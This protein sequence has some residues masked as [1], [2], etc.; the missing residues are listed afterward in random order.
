[1]ALIGWWIGSSD[2]N[3]IAAANKKLDALLARTD[4]KIHQLEEEYDLGFILVAFSG[5]IDT[6]RIVPHTDRIEGDWRRCRVYEAGNGLLGVE[7]PPRLKFKGREGPPIEINAGS[8]RAIIPAKPG[9][10]T[11][12]LGA[13]GVQFQVECLQQEPIGVCAVIGFKEYT[14]Q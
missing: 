4:S 2:P 1:L 14:N 13:R 8:I 11:S 10:K 6:T 12:G 9:E 3:G 5:E 7:L